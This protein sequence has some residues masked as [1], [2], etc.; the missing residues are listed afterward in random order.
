MSDSLEFGASIEG[1]ETVS[2]L[3][4]RGAI[5][6]D[7]HLGRQTAACGELKGA[8]VLLYAKVLGFLAKAIQYFRTPTAGMYMLKRTTDF[9]GM[10]T[11]LVRYIKSALPLL[12][13]SADKH[14]QQ[15]KEQEAEA[16]QVAHFVE[17]E[18]QHTT[19]QSVGAVQALLISLESPIRRLADRAIALDKHQ[20]EKEILGW[21]PTFD[22]RALHAT[23]TSFGLKDTGKW[24]QV[25]RLAEIQLIFNI[26]DTRNPWL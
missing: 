21:L 24:L 7:L 5:L 12:E 2:H 14:M 16:Y 19:G 25:Q 3:V 13:F 20:R 11:S 10:L 17:A 1:I 26:P 9:N 22:F 15:I 4:T 23:F 18:I 6:E 8:L